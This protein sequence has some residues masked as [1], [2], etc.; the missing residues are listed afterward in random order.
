M[1]TSKYLTGNL[2][3][4]GGNRYSHE[5]LLRDIISLAICVLL[6]TVCII[7]KRPHTQKVWSNPPLSFSQG[8]YGSNIKGEYRT[9]TN[10]PELTL[11]TGRYRLQ[12]YIEGDGENTITFSSSNYAKIEPAVFTISP[13][14]Y[15]GDVTFDV[16]EPVYNLCINVNFQSGSTIAIHSIRVSSPFYADNIVLA[17]LA[18]VIITLFA[19]SYRHG[20]L[21]KDRLHSLTLAFSITLFIAYPFLSQSTPAG[22]DVS[23]HAARIM[24]MADA[25]RSGQLVS[26]VGG[27]SYNGYGAATSVFYPD[28][29]L[30]P[31]AILVLCNCTITF[32]YNL[33]I[34]VITFLM[35]L[36]MFYAA[37][38]LEADIDEARCAAIFYVC[39]NY[40]LYDLHINS[41]VGELL[42]MVFLPLFLCSLIQVLRASYKQWPLLSLTAFC[43]FSS[44]MVTTLQCI[45]LAVGLTIYHFSE[46]SNN[47]CR[48]SA[49]IKAIL[50]TV[51][52]SLNRIVTFIDFY[53]SG[54]QTSVVQYG[55]KNLAM[56][57]SQ[58]FTIDECMGPLI[59]IA[60]FLGI[61][62]F[63][64]ETRKN[65]R[66]LL[67]AFILFGLL[68]VFLSSKCFPWSYVD[69]WTHGILNAMI[70]FPSRFLMMTTLLFSFIGGI[71]LVRLFPSLQGRCFL[72]LFIVAMLNGAQTIPRYKE[73]V[74]DETSIQFGEGVSPYFVKEEYQFWGTD[75][76]NTRDHSLMISDGIEIKSYEKKGTSCFLDFSAEMDGS[77]TFPLFGF[78]GY[79][80]ELNGNR[81][82]WHRGFNNRLTVDITEGASGT[83]TV[84]YRGK[85]FWTILDIF[86]FMMFIIVFVKWIS[87]SMREHRELMPIKYKD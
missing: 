32:A 75:V 40:H 63:K 82:G 39:S 58:L 80:V 10:G 30:V 7:S 14:E 25:I 60:L 28:L 17:C 6:C 29:F 12:W 45:F 27:F 78:D 66:Q 8:N 22:W 74:S 34:I 19:I 87:I 20:K 72:M 46:L 71:G 38:H 33:F 1:K 54:V 62:S 79:Y 41:M 11:P 37:R 53:N 44:H 86:S 51:L 42:A 21:N 52:I 31:S 83:I 24:N 16:V 76:I 13:D 4:S 61:F 84:A 81:I 85:I 59:W 50:A 35:F 15:E 36:G 69:N 68:G 57:G 48:I 73:S 18:A 67:Y 49:L 43:I 26:R 64:Y 5:V 65:I 3:F 9:I 56:D 23:F 77:V 47:P 55:M 2:P 70:Q